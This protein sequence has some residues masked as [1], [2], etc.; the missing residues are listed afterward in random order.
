MGKDKKF[1][2]SIVDEGYEDQ[3]WEKVEKE[4]E[5]IE[6]LNKKEE[7]NENVD[8]KQILTKKRMIIFIVWIALYKFF[9]KWEIG[10]M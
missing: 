3:F 2:M 10:T 8:L 7:Y 4:K 6:N 9:I 1:E 5:K